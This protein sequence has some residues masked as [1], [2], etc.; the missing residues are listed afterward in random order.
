MHHIAIVQVAL[1]TALLGTACVHSA[2]PSVA[3]AECAFSVPADASHFDA[4]SLRSLAGD[5]QLIQVTWQPA[6]PTVKHGRLHLEVPDSLWREVPCGFRKVRRDLIG[7]YQA[8][9]AVV[10]GSSFRIGQHCVLDGGGDDFLITAIS[11]NGFWGYWVED[12]GIA[13]VMDT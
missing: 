13:V 6:P 10:R 2:P 3:P 12:M 1:A 8:E 11:R 7:W 4:D 9:R 5:Y